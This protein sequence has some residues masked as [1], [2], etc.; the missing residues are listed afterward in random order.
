MKERTNERMT[1]GN[2]LLKQ[3]QPETARDAGVDQ[4]KAGDPKDTFYVCVGFRRIENYAEEVEL[5]VGSTAG[6]S[7][8]FSEESSA[9]AAVAVGFAF[10]G[11]G[12]GGG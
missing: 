12:P 4:G 10:E 6:A 11:G 7:A 2:E 9:I 5:L 3:R 1:K 8:G